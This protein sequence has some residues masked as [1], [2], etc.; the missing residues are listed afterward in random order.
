MPDVVLPVNPATLPSGFCP[1][2]YQ[3]L[4]NE[5]SANQSV[6][7]PARFVNFISSATKPGAEFQ[8]NTAW[9]Q[10]DS[11]GRPTLGGVFFFAQ[12]AWLQ[13]HPVV[14]GLTQLYF[15]PMD[16][17]G[18]LTFDG[19]DNLTLGPY[20]GKM[21][22]FAT[23]DGTE[24]GTK[25][26]AQIPIAA[27]TLPS[28]KILNVSDVGGNETIIQDVT[29]MPAHT[30][31]TDFFTQNQSGSSTDCLV[32]PNDKGTDPGNVT[33]ES[34]STGGQGSPPVALPMNLMNPYVVC[35][36]LQRTSR[37][38]YRVDA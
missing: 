2:T 8:G 35:Y 26:T 32:D 5:F 9:Q 3:Q 21:W 38:F 1:T 14:P 25:I 37:L 17:T 33:I 18:L 27:G 10:L 20:T 6:T 7:L 12:G 30:H 16:D 29:Q 11:L 19:G 24:G 36:L 22:R 34:N 13:A 4:L 28:G 23:V 15:Q 31:T